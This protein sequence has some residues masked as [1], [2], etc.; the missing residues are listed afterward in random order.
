[1]MPVRHRNTHQVSSRRETTE[2][3][4]QLTISLR[5]LLRHPLQLSKRIKRSKRDQLK[6]HGMGLAERQLFEHFVRSGNVRDVQYE[7]YAGLSLK[8]KPLI[9]LAVQI[10]ADGFTHFLWQDRACGRRVDAGIDGS[11]GQ[12]FCGG[13]R[14]G[15]GLRMSGT[16]AH[17]A[18]N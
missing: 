18:D 8:R 15:C 1:M 10:E 5:G 4:S 16:Y 2:G 14:S 3:A 17:Q 7:S 6:S 11:D 9:D 12:D 13:R